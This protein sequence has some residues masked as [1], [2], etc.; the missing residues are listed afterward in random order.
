MKKILHTVVAAT[1]A[2]AATP[3][4]AD[5]KS[6][7]VS[8]AD[9]DLTDPADFATLEQRVAAAARRVC[10]RSWDSPLSLWSSVEACRADSYH[11][12]MATIEARLAPEENEPIALAD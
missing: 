4:A 2:T 12:A 7:T 8:Y 10:S 6:T 9:L 3:A 11:T 5:E 1:L